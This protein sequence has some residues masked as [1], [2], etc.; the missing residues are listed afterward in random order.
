KPARSAG[1]AAGIPEARSRCTRDRKTSARRSPNVR[2][3]LF[4]VRRLHGHQP[5]DQDVPPVLRPLVCHPSATLQL[6]LPNRGGWR[7]APSASLLSL[8]RAN[9]GGL[10]P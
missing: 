6:I 10:S 8:V 9:V 3:L 5:G 7:S 2:R 1:P 4:P